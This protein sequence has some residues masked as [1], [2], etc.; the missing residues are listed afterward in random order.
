MDTCFNVIAWTPRPLEFFR[1]RYVP[2][3]YFES[4]LRLYCSN[5]P[6]GFSQILRLSETL[7]HAPHV[8][9]ITWYLQYAYHLSSGKKTIRSVFIFFIFLIWG[10]RILSYI[11]SKK[12]LP[13][14]LFSYLSRLTVKPFVDKPARHLRFQGEYVNQVVPGYDCLL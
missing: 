12:V 8:A 5:V 6:S 3:T 2:L 9:V 10:F 1:F 4:D 13:Y 11:Y 14:G 7:S